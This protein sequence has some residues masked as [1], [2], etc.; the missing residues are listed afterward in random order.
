MIR[1]NAATFMAEE[2]A[3]MD[4][5]QDELIELSLSRTTRYNKEV[6]RFETFNLSCLVIILLVGVDHSAM[7]RGRRGAIY[8]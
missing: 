4:T 3:R 5:L 6:P 2:K 1:P 8:L 7:G